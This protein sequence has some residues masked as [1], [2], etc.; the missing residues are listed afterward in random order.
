MTFLLDQGLPRSTI[1]ELADRGMIAEHVGDIGMSRASDEDIIAEAR[2]RDAVVVTL[3]SDFHAHLAA[4]N[5]TDPSVIRVRIE[6]L[7]GDELA[8]LIKHV[9]TIAID[10][11]NAGSAISITPAGIRVRRLPIA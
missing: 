11:L 2:L 10:D 9:A 7:K 8:E 5:A 6:G 4:T 1:A 3:D